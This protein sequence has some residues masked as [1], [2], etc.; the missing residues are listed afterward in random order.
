MASTP[1]AII[2]FDKTSSSLRERSLFEI[3]IKTRFESREPY[4][5]VSSAVAIPFVSEAEPV[6]AS[7][8]MFASMFISPIRVPIIPNA[9]A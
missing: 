3:G 2:S 9:G 1:S 7:R 4:S 6:C 8:S 5:V